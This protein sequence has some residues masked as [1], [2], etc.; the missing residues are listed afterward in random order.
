MTQHILT[1]S[2]YLTNP[3]EAIFDSLKNWNRAYKEHKAYLQT[4]KELSALTNHEL[5]DIGISRSDI[6]AIARGDETLIRSINPN[7]KG[8]V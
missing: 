8:W 4:V 5:N 7:L 1:I 6:H 2:N 3:I